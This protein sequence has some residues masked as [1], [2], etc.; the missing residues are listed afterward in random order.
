[1]VYS[2]GFHDNIFELNVE[3]EVHNFENV[4]IGFVWVPL[5]IMG[6]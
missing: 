2:L 1:M 5:D 4:E 3:V 6:N